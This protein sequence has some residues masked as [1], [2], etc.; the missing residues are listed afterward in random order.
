[1]SRA[2]FSLEKTAKPSANFGKK[3][4]V[5]SAFLPLASLLI[6]GKADFPGELVR[7]AIPR[8]ALAA[9]VMFAV[10]LSPFRLAQAISVADVGLKTAKSFT[11]PIKPANAATAVRLYIDYISK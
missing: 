11:F 9:R 5:F 3:Q 8:P 7:L 1:M 10:L 6:S 2:L 4:R